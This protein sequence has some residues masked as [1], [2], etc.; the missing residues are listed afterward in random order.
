M[1]I[2]FLQDIGLIHISASPQLGMDPFHS[3]HIQVSV[4]CLLPLP[5]TTHH[6]FP[7]D[8]L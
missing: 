2:E 8:H 3:N 4:T 1:A 5:R 7:C 6:T